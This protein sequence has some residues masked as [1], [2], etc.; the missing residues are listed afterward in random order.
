MRD[1]EPL[2]CGPDGV[3]SRNDLSSPGY[4]G[5]KMKNGDYEDKSLKTTPAMKG[6]T[7]TPPGIIR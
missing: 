7:E 2:A 3:P 6:P 5:N 4:A 1:S